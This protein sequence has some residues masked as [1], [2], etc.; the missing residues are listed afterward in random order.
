MRKYIIKNADGSEQTVMQA[1][2]NS[3][4]E[5]G[6]ELMDYICDHNEYLDID[7]DDYLSPFDFI[8]EKFEYTEVNERITDFESARKALGGKPN[9]DFYVVKRKHSEK[10]AHLQE[11]ARLALFEDVARLV[12]DINPKHIKAL[13]ALNELFTIA[14][15]WNKEDDFVPDFS[16]WNQ[17]K[18]FPW[19][20]YDEDVAGFVY[21]STASTPADAYAPFGFR[22][23][24]K[25]SER[26]EQFGKQFDDLYNMVFYK[27]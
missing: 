19:F 15:A 11:A 4:E 22:L 2:H 25:T 23:C 13:I 3:R 17:D 1:V 16:D 26:A 5:A 7:D 8:L 10:V 18:W 9:A 12:T 6:R 14:E 24:F 21:V 20:K 27:Y